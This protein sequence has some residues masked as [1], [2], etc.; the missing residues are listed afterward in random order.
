MCIPHISPPLSGCTKYSSCCCRNALPIAACEAEDTVHLLRVHARSVRG[1]Q[2]A[3]TGTCEAQLPF[4]TLPS[5][6]TCIALRIANRD[7]ILWSTPFVVQFGP[8]N[9][10][11]QRPIVP[12]VDGAILHFEICTVARCAVGSLLDVNSTGCMNVSSATGRALSMPT[13]RVRLPPHAHGYEKDG[14]VSKEEETAYLWRIP[15][16]RSEKKLEEGLPASLTSSSTP[17]ST[18]SRIAAVSL[19]LRGEWIRIADIRRFGSM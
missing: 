10:E 16:V 9:T 3:L 2:A 12:H 4:K 14:D 7:P 15:V 8:P 5:T 1:V 18:Q 6:W 17:R 19:Q 11:I 13:S